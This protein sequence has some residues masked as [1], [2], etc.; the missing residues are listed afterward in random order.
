MNQRTLEAFAERTDCPTCGRGDFEDRRAMRIHHTAA[1]DESLTQQE[2][3]Y[4][5]PECGT[6]V[7]TR[8][9]FGNHLSKVH[10][11]R[12]EEIQDE[13]VVLTLVSRD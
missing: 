2:D 7:Q 10:P 4:R 9:G 1:H 6:E 12:W 11:G 3:R 5:C 8:Q 13:G